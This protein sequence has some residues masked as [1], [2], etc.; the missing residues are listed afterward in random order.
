MTYGADA[1]MKRLTL[2]GCAC[3][4]LAQL[5]LACPALAQ[6]PVEP[7]TLTVE[8]H[9]APGANVF[10]LDQN[11]SGASR[12]NVLGAD[13]LAVKGNI[14]PGL[15]AQMALSADGATLYTVSNYPQRIV[16]GPTEAIVHEWDVATLSLRR[17]IVLPP[18]VAMVEAQPAMLA[19][20]DGERYLLA[21]NATPATS[22]SVVDLEKGEPIA[23]IPTPGCW[24]VIASAAGA[25]FLTLC[26]EGSLKTFSFFPDGS[27]SEPGTVVDVFDP[28]EDAY[29]TN[30]ARAG[31][32]LLFVSFDGDI[33]SIT[34]RD[35]A[36]TV[37]DTFSITEGIEGW[38]PG[39]SEVI[40]YHAES[41]VAFVLMH[42]EAAEGSHKNHAREIWSVDVA[43][44]RLLYRSVAGDENTIAVS[45]SSPPVLFLADDETNVVTRYEV[46][47]EAKSAAKAAGKA[48]DMGRF[49]GLVFT[50]Q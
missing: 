40:A 45:K 33:T 29:F 43:G 22:V 39:G 5:G 21:M 23:E 44:K 34:F 35:G 4:G 12:I 6:D 1:M 14:T 17:E 48:E 42:P 16:F 20:A 19:L 47:P 7:E 8:E 50:S 24:G 18:K 41:G 25:S 30:P 28:Q 32:D 3:V 2:T 38:A 46:D 31:D 49:V 26:G 9:I 27:F 13:D 11:W 36:A 15:Q 10:S 37:G